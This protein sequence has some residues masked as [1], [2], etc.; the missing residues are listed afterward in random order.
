MQLYFS[1]HS[2]IFL[3]EVLSEVK[4]WRAVQQ[5]IETHSPCC[6]VTLFQ[7]PSGLYAVTWQARN[8]L[9]TLVWYP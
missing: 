4:H 7:C 3:K 9:V 5:Q 1:D 6:Q 2:A 8:S